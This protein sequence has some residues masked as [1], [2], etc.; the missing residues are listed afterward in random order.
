MKPKRRVHFTVTNTAGA[1]AWTANTAVPRIVVAAVAVIILM[2][3][4]LSLAGCN[5]DSS[6]D[7]RLEDIVPIMLGLPGTDWDIHTSMMGDTARVVAR[8]PGDTPDVE[9]YLRVTWGACEVAGE[10]KSKP[11]CQVEIQ[12]PELAGA[13]HDC[14]EQ[15]YPGFWARPLWQP[16]DYQGRWLAYCNRG[17]PGRPDHRATLI[18]P[19]HRALLAQGVRLNEKIGLS[20]EHLPNGPFNRQEL[21]LW[22]IFPEEIEG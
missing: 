12:N 11:V 18:G 6:T 9:L 19:L 1:T 14:M 16:H 21:V 3:V 13:L 15:V 2:L 17:Q 5:R 7:P 8:K 20:G 10:I 22:F 4:A